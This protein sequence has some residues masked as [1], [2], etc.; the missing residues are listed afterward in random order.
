LKNW[1]LLSISGLKFDLLRLIKRSQYYHW[2][3]ISNNFQHF[4]CERLKI[5]SVEQ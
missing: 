5:M 1:R 2:Y 3:Q 4:I